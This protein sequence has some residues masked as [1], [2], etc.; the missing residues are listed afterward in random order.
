MQSQSI[1]G[2]HHSN[3]LERIKNSFFTAVD[4]PGST[5]DGQGST[6]DGPGNTVD[7]PGSTI[8]SGSTELAP[9]LEQVERIVSQIEQQE[10]VGSFRKVQAAQAHSIPAVSVIVQNEFMGTSS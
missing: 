10:S 6:V 8:I 9:A 4:G 5:V 1:Y 3:I 2:Q 7:G